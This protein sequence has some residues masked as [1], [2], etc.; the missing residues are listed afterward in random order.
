M[1]EHVLTTQTMDIRNAVLTHV[2][3]HVY[4]SMFHQLLSCHRK[5]NEDQ[6]KLIFTHM[7]NWDAAAM[8]LIPDHCR[9]L[10]K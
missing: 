5:K 8:S 10:R 2:T 6:P 4:C 3:T 1:A 9:G 7:D